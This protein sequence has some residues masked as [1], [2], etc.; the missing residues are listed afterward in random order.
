MDAI[1]LS[2][3]YL[4]VDADD[5]RNEGKSPGD[6]KKEIEES[7]GEVI[8]W[9]RQAEMLNRLLEKE[10]QEHD[11]KVMVLENKK[12][13][14]SRIHEEE[15]GCLKT[16]MK[17]V[18]DKHKHVFDQLKEKVECPVCLE[19]PRSG[20]VHVCPNGHIVCKQCKTGSCPTCRVCMGDGKSLLA[21]TVI[22]NIEHNCKF[23]DCEEIFAV[24]KLEGHEKICKRRTVTCPH[25]NCS[26][27]IALSKLLDHL[28]KETC[29][30]DSRPKVIGSSSKS[31]RARFILTDNLNSDFIWQVRTFTYEDNGFA[32]ITEKVDNLFYITM[33]MFE[34]E[35]ECSKYQIK[36]EVQ[37]W[38]STRQDSEVSFRFCGKPCSIDR[39]KKNLKYH[40]LTVNTIGMEKILRKSKESSFTVSFIFSEK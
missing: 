22:D 25:N 18:T 9:K 14:T 15:I 8:D 29:S 4:F 17:E 24:D 13:E 1:L 19:I 40:G 27:K 16:K 12:E 31:G 10:K 7:D 21:L 23:V 3:R 33:V 35:I 39:E 26:E 11:E 20:P 32:V 38:L 28:N 30:L 36:M 37:E 34:S 6:D 2:I 5:M